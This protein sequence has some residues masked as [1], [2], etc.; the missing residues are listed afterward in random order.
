MSKGRA[1]EPCLGNILS[2]KRRELAGKRGLGKKCG[3]GIEPSLSFG[4][5]GIFAFRKRGMEIILGT[6]PSSA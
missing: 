5:L 4:A 1:L 6:I 2:P 3:V